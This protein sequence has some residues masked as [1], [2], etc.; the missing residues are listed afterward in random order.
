LAPRYFETIVWFAAG[1][2]SARE[3][4]ARMSRS[5]VMSRDESS[6]VYAYAPDVPVRFKYVVIGPFRRPEPPGRNRGAEGQGAASR[7][8]R[9]A[10]RSAA[11][12]TLYDG[13]VTSAITFW[14]ASSDSLRVR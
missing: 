4:S 10:V 14:I 13:V 3:T 8:V 9:S 12:S 6:T 11:L 5:P 2:Q 7:P 1:V